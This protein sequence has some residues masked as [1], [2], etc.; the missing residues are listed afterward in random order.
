V[1]LEE[2]DETVLV[3][4]GGKLTSDC[5]AGVTIR[6][7]PLVPVPVLIHPAD[8]LSGLSNTFEY[9]PS[10]DPSAFPRKPP[11]AL[12][13]KLNKFEMVSSKLVTVTN[14]RTFLTMRRRLNPRAP[15]A[16]ARPRPRVRAK[17]RRSRSSSRKMTTP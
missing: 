13:E 2:P 14:A 3:T 16:T 10:I 8:E 11:Q 6:P 1:T 5:S 7:R 4:I 9:R 15:T 17:S 12:F